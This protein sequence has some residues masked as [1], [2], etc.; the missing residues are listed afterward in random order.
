MSSP[1]SV[2]TKL[3][4]KKVIRVFPRR[5]KATPIDALAYSG[6]PDFFVPKDVEEVHISVSFTWD[7]PKAEWLAEQWERVAP[8][9]VDGP[10]YRNL[11]LEFTPGMYLREGYVITSRGCPQRCWFCDVWKKHP[12][13][14]EL[15]IHDGYALQDDNILAC[16]EAHVRAV[17]AMLKR[18]P[19]RAQFYGGLEPS[20]LKDWHVDLFAWLKPKQMFFA[21]DT[22]DD[23]EPLIAASAMMREAGFTRSQMRCYVLIGGPKDSMLEAE[24]RLQK[25]VDLGFYPFAMLWRSDKGDTDSEWRAFQR[26][27]ARPAIMATEEKRKTNE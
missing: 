21:Y 4:S 20:F 16:S 24:V 25:T 3:S 27:W 6:P 23:L 13:V 12:E 1:K 9:K 14:H 2:Y 8:V 19:Q 26:K 11:D 22:P 15:P 18:Q 17:F 5:T 7:K 10:A